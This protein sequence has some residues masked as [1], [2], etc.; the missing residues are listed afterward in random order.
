MHVLCYFSSVGVNL[1]GDNVPYTALHT[2]NI[3]IKQKVME[4]QACVR[5]ADRAVFAFYIS[6][7]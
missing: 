1:V 2:V 3:T 4:S 6:V 5:F 7:M